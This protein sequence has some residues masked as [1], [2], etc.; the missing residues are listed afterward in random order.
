[1]AVYTHLSQAALQQL[2]AQYDLGELVAA[3]GIAKGVSN[4]NYLLKTSSGRSILTL[5]EARTNP[6]ELPFFMGLME[7]LAALG[8]AC[9]RPLKRRDGAVISKVEGKAAAIVSFLGGEEVQ[10]I[11]PAH[12]HAVGA[13]LAALHRAGEG[14]TL[15]RENGL[16]LAGWQGLY[17]Q[18][19]ARLNDIAPALEQ[20][21]QQE[22]AAL[23]EHWPGVLP[24]G[25]IH[26]DFFPDNVFFE[27]DAVSGIIDFY[28]AC[29]DLLAYDLAI[30]INAWGFTGP[31][32]FRRE[33]AE[34]LMAGY[35]SVRP[36]TKEER[37]AMPLLLRGAVMRFLLTRARDWLN[38]SE[39]ALVTP[40]DP[41]DY[42]MRLEFHKN[43]SW[44]FV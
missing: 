17:A 26:A 33:C 7:H 13:A 35:A 40:H 28:Y 25:I 36:L 2:V 23:A 11:T 44:K 24:R 22:L 4:S 38:R 31:G 29:N 39:G 43:T 12:A 32:V 9:P 37:A 21:V 14:F 19:G 42:I 27:G 18:L 10:V 15:R 30:A 8:I 3:E 6:E 34:A 20:T 5:Y 1:M 41:R 16:G